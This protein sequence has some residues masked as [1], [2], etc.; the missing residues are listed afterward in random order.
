MS[1]KYVGDAPEYVIPQKSLYKAFLPRIVARIHI[2]QQPGA[3]PTGEFAKQVVA[4]S[5]PPPRSLFRSSKW[6]PQFYLSIG[7]KSTVF[8]ILSFLPKT[9]AL[10]FIWNLAGKVKK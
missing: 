2:S 3:M 7:A 6:N 4:A 9:W 5:L 1:H 10:G 8:W